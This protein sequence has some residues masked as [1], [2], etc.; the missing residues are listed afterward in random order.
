MQIG[1]FAAI[2]YMC[3]CLL[4]LVLRKRLL[5]LENVELRH[6]AGSS[7]IKIDFLLLMNAPF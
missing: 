5:E 7:E 3:H 1:V 4:I 6:G 2:N